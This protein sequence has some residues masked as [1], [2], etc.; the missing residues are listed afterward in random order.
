MIIAGAEG[1]GVE[2]LLKTGF[3]KNDILFF[4]Q[5]PKKND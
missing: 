2:V 5:N 4:E 3:S 1:N